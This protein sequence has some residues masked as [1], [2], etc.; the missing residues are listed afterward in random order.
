MKRTLWTRVCLAAVV[1]AA[2]GSI[3][4]GAD[5]KA[6]RPNIVLCMTD[7]QGWGD[8]SYNG[9][10]Q[11]QTPALDRMAAEGLR[12]NRFYAA[13]PLCS[14]TRAS[15]M[16][17]RHP[18]RMGCFTPGRPLRAQEMT[19]AQAVKRA[20]YATG[21]FGKWHLNGVSGP[22]KPIAAD[23]PLNPGRF[24]FDEWLSV[25]NYFETD[26][27]MSRRGQHETFTGD[28][29]EYIVAQALKFIGENVKQKK[30]V[31]AVVWFGNPHTPHKPMPA[32]QEKAG[33][34]AYY[35]E[36][37]AID[38]SM[39]RLREGLRTLG[40][41][42]NTLLWFC[43][44]NG[45][46]APGSTGGLRGRKSSVWEGGLRVPGLVEWPAQIKRPAAT[47]VPACTSDIYPTIVDILGL[48]VPGQVQP[49]DGISL[50]PL[51]D[52]RMKERPTP[53][54]FWHHGGGGPKFDADAGHAAFTDNRYKLHK[55]GADRY[56]LYDL[57]ADPAEATNLAAKQP[58]T[59]AAP[60]SWTRRLAA[61]RA[62]ELPRRGLSARR[63]RR[64]ARKAA[65][66]G[67]VRVD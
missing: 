62:Q 5:E 28:G 51:F 55:L 29:S 16:T 42:E 27:T 38:R 8:V 64:P 3:A 50:L 17:G 57:A 34:S 19:V 7:D 56:E 12:M 30:P 18:N 10:K 1:V 21:H 54:G 26:W 23:D 58:E 59:L 6:P 13:A 43:S 35:G 60:E 63:L 39:G 41:A 2:Y 20:G 33:G 22:G 48:K 52:G 47:D 11:I 14:P 37:L 25:S 65:A 24:G 32:D 67:I 44:D 4:A 40:I 66:E 45:A 46:A 49:L 15:V 53:I 9:L 36:I 61:V 31:L